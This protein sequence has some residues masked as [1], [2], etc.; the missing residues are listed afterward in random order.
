MLTQIQ[1]DFGV[2][3]GE[4]SAMAEKP[5]HVKSLTEEM[6]LSN[7]TIEQDAADYHR[8]TYAHISGDLSYVDYRRQI[9]R[10]G[11]R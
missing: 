4:T 3:T 9:S 10:I 8:I 2:F 6:G 1:R 5:K 11:R 7:T